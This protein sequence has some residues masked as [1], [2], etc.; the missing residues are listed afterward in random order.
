MSATAEAEVGRTTEVAFGDR[1]LT[2]LRDYSV[3]VIVVGL[4]VAMSFTAD[5]FFSMRNFMN[6]LDANAPLM[7]V[8]L[9]TTFVIIAGAFDL[10]TGQIL[11]LGGVLSAWFAVKVG[12]PVAGILL[13]IAWASRSA[14]ST[15][16]WSVRCA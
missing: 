7:L 9:G 2:G 3:V 10:S 1:L 12:D 8:A 14:C 11:S 15:A 13:G 6:I 16:C 4:F 5:N